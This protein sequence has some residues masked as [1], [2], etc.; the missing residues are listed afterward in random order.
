MLEW[1]EE[2][3][4]SF[5]FHFGTGPKLGVSNYGGQDAEEQRRQKGGDRGAGNVRKWY[6]GCYRR[7]DGRSED[8]F[9]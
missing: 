9:E 1:I 5:S 2:L 6:G 8:G 3:L 7:G 4:L